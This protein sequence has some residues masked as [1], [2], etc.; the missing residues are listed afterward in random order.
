MLQSLM[1]FDIS[2]IMGIA[3][4]IIDAFASVFSALA[5]YIPLIVPIAV[6]G[7]I[8]YF[9]RDNIVGFFRDLLPW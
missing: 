9:F 1:S 6:I 8:I 7:T 5:Q 4:A 3:N 2:G